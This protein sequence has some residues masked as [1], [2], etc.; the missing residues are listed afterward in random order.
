MKFSLYGSLIFHVN[1]DWLDMPERVKFKLLSIVHNCL[2]YKVPRY[3]MDYIPNSDV[4]NRQHLRSARHHYLVEPRHSLSSYGRRVFAVVS[5]TAWNSLN[6]DLHDPTLGTDSFRCLFKTCFFQSTS[7]YSALEASHFM[8]YM[9]SRLTTKDVK[10][11]SIN[12]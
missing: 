8:R 12:R 5:P 10:L 4:A 7:R 6:D 3:L 9:N 11:L 1:L 2:H